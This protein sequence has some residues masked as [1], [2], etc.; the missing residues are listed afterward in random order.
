MKTMNNKQKYYKYTITLS[1]VY[2]ERVNMDYG[3]GHG[4][5]IYMDN[6]PQVIYSH[7]FEFWTEDKF[8]VND[9]L[10]KVCGTK[11]IIAINGDFK[12]K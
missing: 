9:L 6:K 4:F 1:P 7:I 11:G 5:V 10:K 8:A 12:N 3:Y 2:S